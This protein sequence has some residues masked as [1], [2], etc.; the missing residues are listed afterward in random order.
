LP[1]FE[2]FLMYLEPSLNLL[3]ISK[4]LI[5]KDGKDITLLNNTQGK[6]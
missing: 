1:F 3:L 5:F 6:I 2:V 4:I